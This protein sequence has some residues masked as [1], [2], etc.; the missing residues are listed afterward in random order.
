MIYLTIFFLQ[1]VC[2]KHFLIETWD[3]YKPHRGTKNRALHYRGKYDQGMTWE[4]MD[5]YHGKYYFLGNPRAAND[6]ELASTYWMDMLW[7]RQS[8]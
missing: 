1:L 5:N 3:T 4:N 8:V 7:Q 2:S 6:Y